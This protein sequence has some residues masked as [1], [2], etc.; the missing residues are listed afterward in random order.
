[1]SRTRIAAVALFAATLAA[2]A[3]ASAGN[4]LAWRDDAPGAFPP[5]F[6]AFLA[7]AILA[8]ASVGLFVALRRPGNR[9]AWILLGGPLSVAVVMAGDGLARYWLGRDTGSTAGAWAAWVSYL[10]PVLFAW[11]VALAFRFPDGRLPSRRW[12]IPWW[13]AVGS[14]GGAFALLALGDTIERDDGLEIPNPLPVHVAR[15]VGEPVFWV[16]W[17]GIVASLVAAVLALRARYRAGGPQE[18]RQVL[19]LAYGAIV[20]PLWL[21]GGSLIGAIWTWPAVLDGVGLAF[22]QVWPAVAVMIAVTRYGLWE[23]DRVLNRTLVYAVLTAL[24]LGAYAAV[25]LGVGALVGRSELT[26]SVAT[27]AAALLFLPLRRRVQAAVDRRFARRRVEATRVLRDFLEDVRAGRA[28][29]EDVGEAVALALGDPTAEILFR[30]P[31]T[32][33][34]ADA[35][36]RLVADASIDVDGSTPIGGDRTLGVLLH[37][38]D[39][40]PEPELLRAVLAEAAL[41]VELARLRV[42]VR[43]QLAEVASSRERIAQAGYA[44]RRRI[45]RDLHDGAQQRLVTLGIVLRRQQRSLPGE[46]RVLVPALDAAVDE[47]A[48]AIG[49]LRTIAAG[50]RPPRLDEGLAAALA[51]LARGAAVPVEV[52]ATPRRAPPDVEAAAYFV[53]CEALTNAVKHAAASRVRMETARED[54]VLRM[55][56]SDD[57]VGGA[58]PAAG[59]GL[60]GMAD[61]VA[62]HGG[63]LHVASP[64]G[65]GTTI[66]VVLPCAS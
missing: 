37:A 54:G 5:A 40:A 51:D 58:V 11:P 27:L 4:V 43:L 30:L 45:E 57:G 20:L 38:T 1:M 17:A 33:G 16:C 59:S 34:L 22:I 13:V 60:P 3:A 52:A 9:V 62:A 23:I 47:V 46:A 29:P 65:A 18:R 32:G 10:W 66:E 2:W 50:V 42:E 25:A 64:P 63:T 56:V 19:W 12:R 14:F 7:V 26:A 49:D 39:P 61:R 21:G 41:P 15:A 28:E 53:A 6:P 31:E 48:A 8:P 44:E 35:E 36:G 24:L 55:T